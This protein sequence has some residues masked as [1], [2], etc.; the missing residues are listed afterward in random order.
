M[1]IN[2]GKKIRIVFDTFPFG[3]EVEMLK[4]FIVYRLLRNR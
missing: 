1:T 3:F 2:Q 4:V